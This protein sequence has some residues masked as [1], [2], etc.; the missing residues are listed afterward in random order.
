MRNVEPKDILL[1]MMGIFGSYGRDHVSLAEF[2]EALIRIKSGLNLSY[3]FMQ[4]SR[5]SVQLFEDLDKLSFDGFIHERIYRHDGFLPKRYLALTEIGAG[6]A[7]K[8]KRELPPPVA[9]IINSVVERTIKDYHERWK[10]WGREDYSSVEPL[11]ER[12]P[13]QVGRA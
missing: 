9:N 10:L 12:P 13:V 7:K 4:H 11:E 2:L 1:A 8:L 6:K 3:E 5:Y